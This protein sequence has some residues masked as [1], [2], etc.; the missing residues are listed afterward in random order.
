M[1]V[2]SLLQNKLFLQYLSGAGSAIAS[3]QP[4]GPA[5]NSITQQNIAA[6]NY[7]KLLQ[8]MLGGDVPKGGKVVHSDKDTTI[9]LPKSELSTDQQGASVSA[10]PSNA[11]VPS[12]GTPNPFDYSQ[13]GIPAADLAGLTPKDISSALSGAVNVK[14]LEEQK[15]KDQAYADYLQA[16]AQQAKQ[17]KKAPIKVPGVGE[18]SFDEWKSLDTKTKAY[19]YY[20]FDT[21]KNHPEEKVLSYNEWL[22]QSDPVAIKQIYDLAKEDKEFRDFYF[23]SKKAGATNISI[24]DKV[25]GKVE[26]GKAAGQIYFNNPKWVDDINKQLESKSVRS[27]IL[28]ADDPKVAKAKKV[29]T[30]VENKIHAGGGVIE[31]V[32]LSEDGKIM[33]WTV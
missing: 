13:S 33:T 10:Q 30:I 14:A 22:Q 6:Q 20:V 29:A 11:V 9:V 12:G 25:R 18:L 31:N 15:I 3:G 19:S 23:E 32:E 27:D 8:R 5:L 17:T 26:L 2:N 24:G 28:L 7:A 4:V 16:I 21:E 1:D